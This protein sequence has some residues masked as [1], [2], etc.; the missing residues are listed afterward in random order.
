MLDVGS[1][2]KPLTFDIQIQFCELYLLS[3][4]NQSIVHG[5]IEKLYNTNHAKKCKSDF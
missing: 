1:S 2:L 5:K 3:Q 4:L